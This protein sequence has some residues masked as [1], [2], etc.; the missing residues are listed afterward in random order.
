MLILQMVQMKKRKV[1][2]IDFFG[3]IELQYKK[4][5]FPCHGQS[6]IKK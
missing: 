2:P 6:I 4:D 3:C 1:K 5:G